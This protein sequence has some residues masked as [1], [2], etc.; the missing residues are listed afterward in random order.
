MLL[1]NSLTNCLSKRLP[2]PFSMDEIQL[3]VRIE[4]DRIEQDRIE[5]DRIEQDRIEQDRIEQD[6][7]SRWLFIGVFVLFINIIFSHF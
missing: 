3:W 7:M 6:L 2:K 5:Q 1:S 4:Q